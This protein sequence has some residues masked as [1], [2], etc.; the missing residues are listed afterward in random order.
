MVVFFAADWTILGDRRGMS[1]WIA[2]ITGIHIGALRDRSTIQHY[3]IAQRMS[4]AAT[5]ETTRLEDI[6]YCLLGIFGI[7]MAMLYGEGDTA[8]KRLQQEIM[9]ISD[10]QSIFAWNLEENAG[11]LCT[12]VLATSPKVFLSCG[13]IVRDYNLKRYPFTVTNLGLSME[14]PSIQT[15]Y[16]SIALVGLNCARELGDSDD[17]LDVLP[18]SKI[19]RRRYQVWIFLCHI[20][21]KIYQRVH[22][23]AST[24]FL[25]AFYI[26]SVHIA[27]TGFFVETQ[28]SCRTRVRSLPDPLIPSIQ[29]TIRV[30]PLSSGLMLTFGC[31]NMN[32]FN[33]YEQVFDFGQICSQTL[34]GR[35]AMGL[36]HELVSDRNFSFIFSVAWNEK[37][38]PQ[39]WTYS[40]FGD[41]DRS[42]SNG[43][44]GAAKWKLLFDNDTVA[45]TGEFGHLVGLLSHIH[46]QLRQDYGE[47]F[48]QASQSSRAPMIK[49]SHHGLQNLHGQCELL[50]DIIFREKPQGVL[51]AK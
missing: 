7:Y 11:E 42:F 41:S 18:D 19:F 51:L 15:W 44:I 8:F 24:V 40:V 46:S 21:D 31:G 10:D 47:A 39:H 2:D 12:G 1:S 36:S 29:K 32:K 13:S 17:P 49:V 35:F 33:R 3:S 48:Q 26:E 30:S 14:L 28:R 43:I 25:Q 22:L 45:F 9:Q 23:P 37:M 16:E 50:V 20:Q 27:K 6:A 5:R 4:W 34:K 38:Q